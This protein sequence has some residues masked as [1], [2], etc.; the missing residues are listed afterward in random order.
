MGA[1]GRRGAGQGGEA[2]GRQMTPTPM[3]MWPTRKQVERRLGSARGHLTLSRHDRGPI[4]ACDASEA[5]QFPFGLQPV[6]DR[7]T[8]VASRRHFERAHANVLVVHQPFGD[9]FGLGR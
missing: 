6:V 7:R 8:A 2:G 9:E 4:V 3:K 1:G 5:E